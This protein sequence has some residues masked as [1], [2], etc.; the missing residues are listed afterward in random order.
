MRR[1]HTACVFAFFAVAA[2]PLF[3]GESA[4]PPKTPKKP[5]SDTY[6]GVKVVDDYQ[7]LDNT[8]A[9]EVKQWI[10]AQ[11]K[12]TRATLDRSKALPALRKRLKELMS[13]ASPSF[14]GLRFG[15]GVL[16]ALKKQPPLDQ[17]LLVTLDKDL[18]SPQSARVILDPNKF[19]AK[20]KTAIDLPGPSRPCDPDRRG[21]PRQPSCPCPRPGGAAGNGL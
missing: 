17:P 7:W 19:D 6:H 18:G 3:A 21:R 2:W 4:G 10:E 8:S 12:Y 20:G 13:D 5:V 16:F 15:G 9:P 11:N 1:L 14:G